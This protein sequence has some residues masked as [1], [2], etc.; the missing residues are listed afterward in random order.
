MTNTRIASGSLLVAISAAGF[1]LMPLFASWPRADG[2]E[3]TAL[4]ALRF[5]LAAVILWSIT[6]VRGLP[7]PPMRTRVALLAMGAILY[8]GESY[9]YY[10]A[11]AHLPSGVVALVFY[12]YPAF[13]TLA[14]RL[15]FG[16][17]LVPRRLLALALAMLGLAMTLNLFSGLPHASPL[18][19]PPLAPMPSSPSTP[20]PL[21]THAMPALGVALSLFAALCYGSYVLAGSRVAKGLSPIVAAAFVATGCSASHTV[22]ALVAHSRPPSTPA[23]WSGLVL[24]AL[25][26]TVLATTTLLEGMKRVGAVRAATISC[27]EPVVTVLVG[28]VALSEHLSLWQVVGGA[29]IIVAAALTASSGEP[30]KEPA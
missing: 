29:L 1:G 30:K 20:A 6:L 27:L 11:L 3:P 18:A 19:Q 25:V 23:G 10:A 22:A 17:R 14:A 16:E 5:A 13:V 2:T 4:L 12:I 15:L 24:L 26:G 8:F 7:L 28:A 9:G 21:G